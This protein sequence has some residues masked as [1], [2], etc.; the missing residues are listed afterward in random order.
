VPTQ[1]TDEEQTSKASEEDTT[2]KDDSSAATEKPEP[3]EDDKAAAKEMMKA[4]VDRPTLVVPGSGGAISG[5]AVND[6]VDENGDPK[7]AD[8]E[9]APASKAKA[10]DDD[11]DDVEIDEKYMSDEQIK[12]DKEYNEAVLKEA[13]ESDQGNADNDSDKDGD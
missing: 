10:N 1:E 8:D 12:K 4:Y 7:F 9:D 2:D 13:E 3:D 11:S 5:T 6:W